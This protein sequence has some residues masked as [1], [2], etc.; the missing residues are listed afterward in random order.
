[1]KSCAWGGIIPKSS[2]GL[3]IIGWEAALLRR[4]RGE[5]SVGP[6]AEHKSAVCPGSQEDQQPPRLHEKKHSQQI[7]MYFTLPGNSKATPGIPCSV[8]VP[9]VEERD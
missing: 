1:M 6:Q 8:L 2:T 4:T 9:P 3:W 7:K 5:S